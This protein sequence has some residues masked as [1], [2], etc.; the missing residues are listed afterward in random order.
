MA[1]RFGRLF[2]VC[3]CVIA[4]T[5]AAQAVD[6]RLPEIPADP[7]KPLVVPITV[8]DV[9]GLNLKGVDIVL[10][11]SP[12]VLTATGIETRGTL[13]DGWL[14]A[15]LVQDGELRISMATAR[16]T[17]G[18]G[19]LLNATFTVN[20]KATGETS[21]TFG[22]LMFNE[23]RIPTTPYPG[24][25]TITGILDPTGDGVV[26]L[27]DVMRIA[28]FFGSSDPAA[29]LNHDGVV[30]IVMVARQFGRKAFRAAPRL[31]R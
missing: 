14:A 6:V 11:F 15:H 5:S 4:W 2:V 17:T 20:P 9:T 8:D 10:R 16:A 22:K 27:K 7:A 23:N 18:K 1:H 13:T 21:I 24:K 3:A 29:D 19:V 25:V 30:D 31:W 12:E 28:E 26:D